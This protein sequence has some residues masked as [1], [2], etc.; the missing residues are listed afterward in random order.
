[1]IA[2]III[3][4]LI[5]G[6]AIVTNN[7]KKGGMD[8]TKIYNLFA[9]INIDEEK[10]INYN[11]NK[12]SEKG[13]SKEEFEE[14][15]SKFMDVYSSVDTIYIRIDNNGNVTYYK[16]KNGLTLL[17]DEDLKKEFES[18]NYGN[19]K[20]YYMLIIREKTGEQYVVSSVA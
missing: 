8:K 10:I 14:I 20:N 13:Y 6:L 19:S 5:M 9:K 2:A 15:L 3:V 4:G 16:Y 17:D 7:A 11:P 12:N 1:M 18:S